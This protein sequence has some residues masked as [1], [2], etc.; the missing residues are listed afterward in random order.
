[1]GSCAWDGRTER[2]KKNNQQKK[3]WKPFWQA[4]LTQSHTST[5]L[6]SITP[7]PSLYQPFSLSRIFYVWFDL[8]SLL[9]LLNGRIPESFTVTAA[10]MI[11]VIVVDIADSKK[12]E[13][14]K[15][16]INKLQLFNI[17]FPLWNYVGCRATPYPPVIGVEISTLKSILFPTI[18]GALLPSFFPSHLKLS[19][20][21]I[22]LIHY[23]N[24]LYFVWICVYTFHCILKK[25]S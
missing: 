23:E 25:T 20:I 15:K 9:P 6:I 7:P 17:L 2:K 1:M 18:V 19:L 8:L 12:N 24:P 14:T 4:F 21:D 16:K 11:I 13:R 3:T 22:Q 10:R 5:S